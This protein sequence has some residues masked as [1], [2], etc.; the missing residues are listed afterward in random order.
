[1]ESNIR[2]FSAAWPS[3]DHTTDLHWK[4]LAASYIHNMQTQCRSGVWLCLYPETPHT[5]TPWQ[6]NCLY[7]EGRLS[8]QVGKFAFVANSRARSVDDT[9][10]LVKFISEKKTDKILGAHIM[11]PNAGSYSTPFCIASSGTI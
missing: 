9:E 1:M 5:G 7:A 11:G 8:V 4:G 3:N 10:G 6:A 2:W